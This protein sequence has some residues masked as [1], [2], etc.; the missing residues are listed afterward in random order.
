MSLSGRLLTLFQA[1]RLLK[2]PYYVALL[3]LGS[4]MA[5]WEG[6][7]VDVL[8]WLAV[9]GWFVVLY[10]SFVFLND[11]VDARRDPPTAHT[12][13]RLGFSPRTLF[14]LSALGI[15]V[16]EAWLG[17]F[18]RDVLVLGNVVVVLGLL[19]HLPPSKP[20]KRIWPVGLLLLAGIGV[21]V[22]LAGYGISGA[23]P[24]PRAIKVAL[25]IG[26][27]LFLVFGNKD[28]KDGEGL[29]ALLP[30]STARKVQAIFT[31]L[32]FLLPPVFWGGG[33][34]YG[35][36][37]FVLGLFALGLSLRDP[38]RESLFWLLFFLY[39]VPTLLV[40]RHHVAGG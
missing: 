14:E 19:Y 8:R 40:L 22:I 20:L 24:S 11:G 17:F 4:L 35:L 31:F 10:E 13:V 9:L 1:A 28:R 29:W 39:A 25:E 36:L 2:L 30:D 16:S 3:G 33:V 5:R 7:D 34:G 18:F 23:W 38:Y 32:A 26:V 27:C 37:A 15:L 6:H 12:W 21:G